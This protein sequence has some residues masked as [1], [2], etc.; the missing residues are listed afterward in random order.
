MAVC[1]EG[2]QKQGWGPGGQ[3]LTFWRESWMS[4][5]YPSLP[6]A[7]DFLRSL[8][9]WLQLRQGCPFRGQRPEPLSQKKGPPDPWT[10]LPCKSGRS[11]GHPLTRLGCCVQ[12]STG[13]FGFVPRT[14]QSGLIL[15]S[16]SHKPPSGAPHFRGCKTPPIHD[17]S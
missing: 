9:G 3:R 15:F 13:S 11:F 14:G 4:T 17:L 12:E 5:P 10:H 16:W 8:L 2:V 1:A 6:Q 7:P